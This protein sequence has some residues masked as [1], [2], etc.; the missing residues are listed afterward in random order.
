VPTKEISPKYTV[1]APLS[2]RVIE[3][4]ATLGEVVG[5]DRD[6]LMVLAD[7]T[8]L[9]VL[10]DVP[11][12]RVHEIALDSTATVTVKVGVERSHEG[13]VAYIAP[14]LDKATR[15]AQVRIEVHDSHT[16]LRPGMFTEVKLN[17][18]ATTSGLTLAVPESSVLTVEGAASVFAAVPDEPNT[19]ARKAVETGPAI[20]SMLPIISGLEEGALVVTD[21][22]FILKAEL[23][24]SEM[25]GKT[26]SGH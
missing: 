22:A 5:P 3:R 13:R 25:E 17:C 9:W 11:E 14:A 23:A 18:A 6:A 2:G 10:A 16:D 20:G 26:C 12:A 19:Y 1:Y 24:K 8:T 15:T 7:M 21:G 4:E